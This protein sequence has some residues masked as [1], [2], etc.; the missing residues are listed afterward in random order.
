[1]SDP[2][3]RRGLTAVAFLSIT[4][5][6]ACSHSPHRVE[7][8][9][10]EVPAKFMNEA[11]LAV[12]QVP[13]QALPAEWWTA[14]GDPLIDALVRNALEHNT[15]LAIARARIDE[16]VAITRRT[17]ASMFPSLAL[18]PQAT[19]ARDFSLAPTI[20]SDAR[21]P[22]SASWEVDLAGRLS[23]AA[24]G[25][26]MD[27]VAVEQNWFAT[28]WQIAF[29][30]VSAA[31][32]QRQAAELEDL[33]KERL[34]VAERLERLTEQ[35]FKAGQ[36][37]GFDIERT[38][39]EVIALRVEQEQL[40][41][42][43]GE[44][45]HALDVLVGRIPGALGSGPALASLT[46]PDWTPRS[47]PGEL[48][49]Q[50][51]DVRAAQARLAAATARW[52]AAEGERLPKLVLDL[53]GGRQRFENNGT[54]VA[55][56]IFSLGLGVTLPIFDGGA[57]QAGIDEGSARSR[58][59][60]ADLER[61]VLL[62]LQ[63]VENAYLGWQTQRTSLQHQVD[64]LVVAD[65]L[66]DRSRR[67]FEAGQVDATVVAEAERGTL[68][69]RAALVRARADAAVQWGVLAKA[70]SGSPEHVNLQSS[71]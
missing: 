61:T 68:S 35:K 55:G 9:R 41:R 14:Y 34:Q 57:I 54:R 10:V 33:A 70:L 66:L 59:A 37:T 42:V 12:Q 26:R 44:A 39:S 18:T 5:L 32:Q 50:R 2:Y 51:P 47:V 1:M 60:Q 17:R 64:G 24:D 16:A 56:N 28:R 7:T 48:L 53:S 3:A 8:S 71:P 69:Q 43:R 21:L 20:S 62:A 27:A 49:Q 6:A 38:R 31:L 25:A 67:L 29:E 22:L 11:G 63:D 45:T 52:N 36:A 65:R 30:T 19:R 4:L 15:D 58:G 40:R 46:M 23:H 13:A